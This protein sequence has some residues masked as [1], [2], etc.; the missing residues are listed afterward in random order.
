ML[1]L[2]LIAVVVRTFSAK[3]AEKGL[4]PKLW[5]FIGAASYYGPILMMSFVCLPLIIKMGIIELRDQG[6]FFFYSTL[7]NLGVGVFSCFMA[8]WVLRNLTPTVEDHPDLLDV[9]MD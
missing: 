4:S 3:A 6:D 5:G 8:Y 1:E 9:D 7:L 2:I